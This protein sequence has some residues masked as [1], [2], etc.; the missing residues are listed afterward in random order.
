M[1]NI[2]QSCKY[3]LIEYLDPYILATL[4]KGSY[5]WVDESYYEPTENGY[6]FINIII[7]SS[8]PENME[9]WYKKAEALGSIV[10][11][12]SVSELSSKA[13]NISLWITSDFREMQPVWNAIAKHNKRV[14]DRVA[15]WSYAFWSVK[16]ISITILEKILLIGK[17]YNIQIFYDIFKATYDKPR[18]KFYFKALNIPS[19]LPIQKE[20]EE[21]IQVDNW[22]W[23]DK[24]DPFATN[25]EKFTL[26][27]EENI[28]KLYEKIQS[29]FK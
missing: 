3:L 25:P 10:E 29:Y 9:S 20:I 13:E 19:F 18:M 8:S 2:Y 14:R 27:T 6:V 22:G 16:P 1:S 11:C 15:M 12:K 5:V 26:L 28:F 7:Y 24:D 17:N 4:D 21:Y 23:Q